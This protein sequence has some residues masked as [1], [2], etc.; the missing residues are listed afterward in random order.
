MLLP[1]LPN[2]LR[3]VAAGTSIASAVAAYPAVAALTNELVAG[4][5]VTAS[6]AIIFAGWHYVGTEEGTDDNA[7]WRRLI[8]GAGSTAFA[9]AM[10]LGIYASGELKLDTRNAVTRQAHDALYEQQEQSRMAALEKLTQE[11]RDTSKKNNPHEYARLQEQIKASSIPTPRQHGSSLSGDAVPVEYKWIA[12]GI[13]E[14]ATPVLLILAGFFGRRDKN[15]ELPP[16]AQGQQP[17][18]SGATTPTTPVNPDYD[19]DPVGKIA[20]QRIAANDDGCVTAAAVEQQTGCT[21]KQA[22]A[23]IAE[24]VSHGYLVKTGTGGGTRYYYPN[25]AQTTLLWRV[26]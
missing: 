8:A 12:A 22:R 13:F 1:T 15:G 14:I 19:P 11:L 17:A 2:G 23:A 16:V 5:A 21:N 6:A 4:A 24:A 18:N 26:K 25:A 3:L 20:E 9:A 7:A 10:V